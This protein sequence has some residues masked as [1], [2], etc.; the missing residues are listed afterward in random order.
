MEEGTMWVAALEA[1]QDH[2]LIV[3]DAPAQQ[4]LGIL[5][6]MEDEHSSSISKAT[7]KASQALL[8]GE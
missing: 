2:D 6:H 7:A 4:V 5:G 3:E 8:E 1:R